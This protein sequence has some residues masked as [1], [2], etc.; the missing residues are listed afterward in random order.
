[1]YIGMKIFNQFSL[2]EKPQITPHQV[3][4]CK[5]EA[6]TRLSDMH[7]SAWELRVDHLPITIYCMQ[8]L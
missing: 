4:P 1:M 2:S 3:M 8:T 5:V 7:S 6:G